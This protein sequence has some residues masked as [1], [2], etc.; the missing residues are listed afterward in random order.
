M[1]KILSAFLSLLVIGSQSLS[2]GTISFDQLATSSDL[3]VAK[4]NADLNRIY[5]EFNSNTE[6]SNIAVDTVAEVDMADDANP[7]LRTYE[8][9]A[10]EKVYTGLLPGTTSATLT[11]SIPS[12]TAYP[13]GYRVVKSS[14]TSKT[15]TASK[16]T[17]VDIDI[18][19]D[20]T[21]SEVAI[22][23]S[24]PAVATNSIRLARVST[25]GTQVG[26]VQ[27]LRTTSCATGPFSIIADVT[28][29]ASLADILKNGTPVRRFS[30]A[31]RTP[32]GWAQGALVSW[33]AH[34][35]FKVTAGSLYINGKYR[36][37]SQDISLTTANDSPSTGI[38]GLDTGTVTGG[39]LTYYVYGVAD[40]DAVA[41]FSITYSTSASAP[42]G[43]TNYRYLGKI[44]T[45]ATNLFTSND[46]V[47]VH[48]VSEREVISAWINA[49]NTP[50]TP[51][52]L[53]SYNVASMT[54]EGA[55]DIEVVVDSDFANAFYAVSG[56][57]MIGDGA[58]ST[59]AYL[60]LDRGAATSP[61][62]ATTFGVTCFSSAGT[63]T[64]AADITAM[65]V[66]DARR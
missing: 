41:T 12:G 19:G 21:F 57:C 17:F 46:A 5:Q 44:K 32:Q 9:A 49:D 35:T 38:S 50:A 48:G 25:D 11:G 36:A 16:W 13:L 65:A 42:T 63:A 58:P 23:G 52:I 6:S 60:T 3:T 27:D 14:S 54:D 7:R 20:F 29:E 47:T 8:G 26:S 28:S 31:G 66:G 37:V 4:Y 61:I 34:T 22:N 53:D 39:P 30:I 24:T 51:L 18:N 10:C 15:W 59:L 43:V 55:G 45:D 64:D 1:K 2:A 33:D 40:Q 56:S 62:L